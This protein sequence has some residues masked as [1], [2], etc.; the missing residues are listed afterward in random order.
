MN[1]T[2]QAEVVKSNPTPYRVGRDP[3]TPPEGLVDW[4]AKQLVK[5]GGVDRFELHLRTNAGASRLIDDVDSTGGAQVVAVGLWSRALEY[6][7]VVTGATNF[8][9]VALR[10]SGGGGEYAIIVPPM[11]RIDGATSINTADSTG[12]TA[13]T[14]QTLGTR[15]ALTGTLVLELLQTFMAMRTDDALIQKENRRAIFQ[16]LEEQRKNFTLATAS[17]EANNVRLTEQNEKLVGRFF[18]WIDTLEEASSHKNE[19]DLAIRKLDRANNRKDKFVDEIV[20]KKVVPILLMKMGLGFG[21]AAPKLPEN[22]TNGAPPANGAPA[23]GAANPNGAN[24]PA[25]GH[26]TNGHANGHAASTT[27]A[28]SS[29]S[30]SNGPFSKATQM[31]IASFVM[32]I[33]AADVNRMAS[34]LNED[35]RGKFLQMV[36]AIVDDGQ[37]GES[38]ST[39]PPS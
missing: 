19:Q 5:R 2:Q 8:S 23:N 26:A 31:T 36:N 1:N 27:P 33:E 35:A 14:M 22:G 28:T 3:Q 38:S 6:G 21:G 37:A 7:E 24:G 29:S 20:L 39:E 15:D 17:T 16:L 25:N 30:S 18:E 4:I 10:S 32:S 13:A 11:A 34:V 9:V 12:L